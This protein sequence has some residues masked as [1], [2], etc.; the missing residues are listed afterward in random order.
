VGTKKKSTVRP[1]FFKPRVDTS[2][3]P[4]HQTALPLP[5]DGWDTYSNFPNCPII[6]YHRL[7][8]TTC[9]PH[10]SQ[11]QSRKSPLAMTLSQAHHSN[12]WALTF[13]PLCHLLVSASNDHTAHFWARERPG[14]APSVFA[15]GRRQARYCRPRRLWGWRARGR[16]RR[17]RGS[18][19]WQLCPCRARRDQRA[20]WNFADTVGGTNSG[21]CPSTSTDDDDV[22]G[23][24]GRNVFG[25]GGGGEF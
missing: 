14:D 23:F 25:L 24:G 21:V 10:C 20:S 13:H 6:A 22:P 11:H 5:A 8:N 4:C 16:G 3:I 7:A 12:V 15:L 17:T 9:R 18:Q 1:I 2:F 19:L